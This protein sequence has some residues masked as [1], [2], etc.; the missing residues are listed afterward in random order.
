MGYPY[1]QSLRSL[2][3][4]VDEIVVAHGD[5]SDG[6]LRSLEK[7]APELSCP[8]R[9][10]DSPWDATRLKGG[11]E[12]S[13]QTNV[14]LDACQSDVCFYLQA[15]ELLHEADYPRMKEDL[16]IFKSDSTL[17]ALAFNWIHFYG[18]FE[19]CVYSK[20]WYR[21][22][23]RVVKKSS[24]LRSFGDA[25]GFRIPT[26][27]DS[28]R[29]PRAALSPA[30]VMHYGWVRPPAT[31]ATKSESLD[32]LWHGN[33]RDG[34]HNAENIYRPQYGL[35]KFVGTHP[36]VMQEL[37]LKAEKG[38]PFEGKF[39]TK[40]WRYL[41][42]LITDKIEQATGWRPGEFRNYETLRRL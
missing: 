20:A 32:R 14:A 10:L 6:T 19:T 24:G 40:D 30:H 7:L 15:D 4:M 11:L 41:R 17:D 23:I 35:S 29:K 36:K 3:P 5:S 27:A 21:R 9:I 42:L 16:G 12:L 1:L 38:N 26:G 37:V 8:L 34:Q 18:N 31:M 2:A 28:W 25:Q 39:V 33:A 13:R 22:E